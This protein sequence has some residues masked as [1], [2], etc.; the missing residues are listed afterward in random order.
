MKIKTNLS[1]VDF[2]L[3]F[4]AD[5]LYDEVALT[6]IPYY[7]FANRGESDMIIWFSKK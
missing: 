4:E 6:L 2:K 5:D 1:K 3:Y 7:A